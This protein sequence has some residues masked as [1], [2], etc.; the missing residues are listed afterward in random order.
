MQGRRV[1]EKE[2]QRRSFP[3]REFIHGTIIAH[4]A[5]QTA[6]AF[7]IAERSNLIA[8]ANAIAFRIAFVTTS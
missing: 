6:I 4:C 2:E 8:F 7:A 1:V 3:E 5:L